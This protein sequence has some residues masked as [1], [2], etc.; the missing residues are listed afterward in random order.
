[1]VQYIANYWMRT[2]LGSFQCRRCVAIPL[3]YLHPEF[4]ETELWSRG[5]HHFFLKMEGYMVA[6][7]VNFGAQFEHEFVPNYKVLQTGMAAA[8]IDKVGCPYAN[9][10]PLVCR[11]LW[12]FII[13]VMH[14]SGSPCM[15]PLTQVSALQISPSES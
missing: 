14:R 6:L 15:C 5:F 7:Q 12:T 4:S 2:I 13:Q 3:T 9:P 8:H 1:M 10:N 11:L